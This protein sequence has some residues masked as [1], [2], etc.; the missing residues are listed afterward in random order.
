MGISGFKYSSCFN[1]EEVNLTGKTQ[2]K[3]SKYTSLTLVQICFSFRKLPQ[4]IVLEKT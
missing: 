3:F 4:Q 2:K 1:L